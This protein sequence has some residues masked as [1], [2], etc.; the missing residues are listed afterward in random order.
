MVK[1][2]ENKDTSGAVEAQLIALFKTHK[3]FWF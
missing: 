2:I 1:Q 3:E